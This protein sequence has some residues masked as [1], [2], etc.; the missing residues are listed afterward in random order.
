MYVLDLTTLEWAV[1]WQAGQSQQPGPRSRYFHSAEVWRNY[2]VVFGGESYTEPETAGQ[3]ASDE[4]RLET[5]ADMWVFDTTQSTWSSPELSAAAGVDGPTPRYAHLAAILSAK[6]ESVDLD[7]MLVIGGQDVRN[8]YLQSAHVLDLQ[9]M[10]WIHKSSWS[11]S[12]GTYRA[13]AAVESCHQKRYHVQGPAANFH[14]GY[15]RLWV[16]SNSNFSQVRRELDLVALREDGSFFTETFAK[17]SST[18]EVL[19]PPGLRFPGGGVVDQ[20]LIVFGTHLFEEAN[21]F[22]IWSLSLDHPNASQALPEQSRWK[23]IDAGGVFGHGRSW[24]RAVLWQNSIVALGNPNRDLAKDYDLR[25]TNFT[26]V[27]FVDLEAHGIHR[28]LQLRGRPTIPS[29]ACG[30]KFL[31]DKA[32]ADFE[33]K[34]SDGVQ[35]ACSRKILTARWPWFSK[36]MQDFVSRASLVQSQSVD[37]DNIHSPSEAGLDLKSRQYAVLPRSLDLPE[38]STIVSTFL[39]YVY[40]QKL[41][42]TQRRLE[43]I[44]GLLAFAKTYEHGPLRKQ[45]TVLLHELNGAV[46]TSTALVFESA[47]LAGCTA[48]QVCALKHL[49]GQDSM[50]DFIS[51]VTGIGASRFDPTTLPSQQGK[52]FLITGGHAGIGL[53]TTRYIAKA[54]ARVLMASRSPEKARDAIRQLIAEDA[55]LESRLGFHQ[56]DLSS[57]KAVKRA[58]Q[59]IREQE[60]RLDGIICNAGIMACPYELTEDGIE[61][62]FQVNHLSHWLLIQILMPLLER[63][64]QQ[65]GHPSRVVNLSSFAHTFISCFPRAMPSFKALED[66]NRSFEPKGWIRYSQSKLAAILSAKELNKRASEHVRAL[67]VHPGF[68][69]SDLYKST[70][71]SVFRATF[72]PLEDGALSSVWATCS[73]EVEEENKFGEYIVPHARIGK[74]TAYGTDAQLASDLWDLSQRLINEKVGGIMP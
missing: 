44:T 20:H 67:S 71:L 3:H 74:T 68:V 34:C 47:T 10:R 50:F 14:N 15:D 58:A 17:S 5:L 43:L 63:T 60:A 54:G 61:Q 66:V 56:L 27:G 29:V 65:T 59:S 55:N 32:A 19:S 40:T 11:K 6:V 38:P 26:H 28:D 73:P 25:R 13:V 42:I 7:V 64:A 2:I 1:R 46:P 23:K 12:I 22:A 52:V 45:C 36:R 39:L 4:G 49:M 72:I 53:A 9:S 18:E 24:N 30:S 62:Q 16:F 31:L 33:I 57:L 70:R 51:T 69:K 37:H 41:D 35:L 8:T 21:T 48:L